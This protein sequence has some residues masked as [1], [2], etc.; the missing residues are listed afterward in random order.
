MAVEAAAKEDVGTEV[1]PAL[2][3]WRTRRVGIDIMAKMNATTILLRH[4][5][6][7]RHRD[8]RSRTPHFFGGKKFKIEIGSSIFVGVRSTGIVGGK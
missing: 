3:P 7:G 8:N 4:L 2:T 6:W 5:G 1:P